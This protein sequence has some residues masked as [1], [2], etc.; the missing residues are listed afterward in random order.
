MHFA[1]KIIRNVLLS[2]VL[3]TMFFIF[4]KITTKAWRQRNDD[5]SA[6]TSIKT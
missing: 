6:T 3:S 1:V 2:H 5:K 4:K